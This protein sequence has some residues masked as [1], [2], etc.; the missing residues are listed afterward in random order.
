LNEG[1][2][3]RIV[4]TLGH[5]GFGTV[6]RAELLGAGGF[7]KHVALK[8]LNKEGQDSEQIA[9]RFRDEAR[10]LGLINHRAVV[11][12]DGLAQF[13]RGFAVV[14]EY[15]EGVD[16]SII[17]KA[18]PPLRACLEI[19][20]EV[21]SALHTAYAMP[22]R[23]TG[24]PLKLVHRD[25]K[26]AN[27]RVT[28]SGEVKLLDFGVARAE[29]ANR[30][31]HTEQVVLGTFAWMA[32]ERLEGISG[33]E[34]DV[35]ALGLVL[36]QMLTGEKLPPPTKDE[37]KYPK[38][39]DKLRQAVTVAM[40]GSLWPVSREERVAVLDLI[41]KMIAFELE[42]R[43]SARE[44]ER[45][46]RDLKARASGPW[47]RE[48]AEEH[49]PA[50]VALK[51]GAAQDED[52]MTGSILVER[53]G[54]VPVPARAPA[55]EDSLAK[56]TA[57]A[58]PPPEPRKK[59]REK[60]PSLPPQLPPP[61][62]ERPSRALPFLLLGTAVVVLAVSLLLGTGGVAALAVLLS[63]E[64]AAPID[65]SAVVPPVKA[66]EPQPQPQPEPAAAPEPQP[67]P[68]PEP[69]AAP[70]ATAAPEPEPT[71]KAEPASDTPK[72]RT[73]VDAPSDAALV[74]ITG[75]AKKVRLK[76]GGESY[77][78]GVVPPGIYTIVAEFEGAAEPVTAEQVFLSA[79]QT[80]T[81][82]CNAM[83][84]MCTAL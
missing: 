17:R 61:E 65:A 66:A 33:P 14:M 47:L 51:R 12:V 1:R 25:V 70:E 84:M 5:G 24:E 42:D 44:V 16:V 75:D 23:A 13:D 64:S 68:Q 2:R 20:E 78:A 11:Q 15:V 80:V 83:M 22:S 28:A 54:S 6:Y 39:V 67:E 57:P 46:C 56:S 58:T 82:R 76:G 53:S 43:P 79:G 60:P 9:T 45:Q 21:A 69:A 62:P 18:S 19:V 3:Y 73:R 37:T 29:F 4:E 77:S 36:A 59:K 41:E 32:P 74:K 71:P 52:G 27:I 8:V 38:Y 48:W 30:E 35:Y 40:D 34:G 55:E 10:L 81:I 26:P 63:G 49:V 7:T 50:L 31:A 72:S